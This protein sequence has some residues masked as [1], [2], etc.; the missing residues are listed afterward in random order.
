[1]LVYGLQLRLNESSPSTTPV[2]LPRSLYTGCTALVTLKL[3]S[4]TLVD[5]S[6]LPSFPTLKALSLLL[7]KFPGDA[8]VKRLFSN[9][10][11]LQYLEV[12]RLQNDNVTVFTVI[13]PSLKTLKLSRISRKVKDG[14]HGSVI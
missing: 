11:V 2:M 6:S 9:C 7:V 1:M 10:H 14:E 3:K 8:F 12:G 5:V 4:V 13:V